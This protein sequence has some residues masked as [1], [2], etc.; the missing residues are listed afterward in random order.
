[1]LAAWHSPRGYIEN[2]AAAIALA[3]TDERPAR[4]IYNVCEEPSF[5]ELEWARKITAPMPWATKSPSLPIEHT[6]PHLRKPSV[7]T[8]RIHCPRHEGTQRDGRAH[9]WRRARASSTRGPNVRRRVVMN[10]SCGLCERVTIEPLRVETPDVRAEWTVTARVIGALPDALQRAQ[11]VF[12]ET[13]GLHEAGLFEQ[14]GGPRTH[15]RRCRPAQ[16]RRQNRR[17]HAPR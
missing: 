12:E 11:A 17:P 10:S 15:C 1:M 6:P 2:V 7:A 9:S 13:G 14:F 4:R 16:C 5:S 8:L 3:A